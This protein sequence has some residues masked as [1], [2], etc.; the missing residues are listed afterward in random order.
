[1][2][3]LVDIGVNLCDRRFGGDVAE[4]IER[5]V[6]AGVTKMLVTG[7]CLATSQAALKLAEQ[8]PD[9]LY[10]TA[11]VHPHH[12][13]EYAEHTSAELLALSQ[14]PNCVAIG[15]AGLD[16]NRNFSTP[17][18]QLYAFEAQLQL[19][20]ER[21]LPMFL[22]ERD[23]FK[24]QYQLLRH[25]R[26]QLTGAV[27]HCFT[28]SRQAMLAYLELDLYIGITGWV[29]DERRGLELAAM[30]PEIPLERLLL[31][32]DAPYLTPRNLRPKPKKGRN[33]P[34]VLPH[35][36]REVANLYGLPEQQ[37]A[38]HCWNNSHQLFK[39]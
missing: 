34:A 5:A 25:Y 39:L 30:L 31:E 1:M 7:T 29:C 17:S 3:Q 27:V 37:I 2:L 9:T 22:H 28:G 33:E 35:I 11:G 12:A 32:T 20:C 21:Q 14:H 4:V 6:E 16:F 18:E 8:Y 23:A 26:P 24:E 36:A 10:F 13:S 19:A 15:E 38:V